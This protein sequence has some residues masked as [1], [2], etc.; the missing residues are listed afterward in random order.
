MKEWKSECGRVELYCGDSAKILPSIKVQVDTVI[1]DPPAGISFMNKKWDKNKG[2]RDKWIEWL[3]GIIGKCPIKPGGLAIVW[4]IPRT[5]H[6]T[7]MAM[8]D[9]G[10]EIRDVITHIFGSGFPKSHNVANSI[11]KKMGCSNRGHA[12]SSGN[13]IHPTTGKARAPGEHLPKYEARTPEGQEWSGYGTGLKPASENWIIGMVPREG[14]FASNA[15]KHGCAGYNIDGCRVGT[16]DEWGGNKDNACKGQIYETLGK[17]RLQYAMPS[18]PKG[19]FPS[20]ILLSH[21]PECE[22]IGKKKVKGRDNNRFKKTDGGSFVAKFNTPPKSDITDKDGN[23]TI[24]SYSCH[25]DCPI[26]MMN[27]QSGKSKS[28]T[29]FCKGCGKPKYGGSSMNKSVTIDKGGWKYGDEGG[30]SRFFENF[31]YDCHPDCPIKMMNEQSGKSKSG[32]GFCKSKKIPYYY[33]DKLHGQDNINSG[34]IGHGDEG[35]ASRFFENFEGK[36]RFCYSPKASKS[37]RNKGCD[38]NTHPTVKPLKLLQWL[39]RLTKT[40]TG[41]TVLDPFMGSG[42]IGVAALKEGREYIGIEQDEEYF[43]IAKARIMYELDEQSSQLF[44]GETNE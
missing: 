17:Y 1:T 35:G 40:P 4:A 15:L 19:R 43:E 10:L 8:E 13:K 30:A 3:A 9:A 14:T 31:E 44:K 2:G 16:T 25:P 37:E 38:K 27:D 28:Q 20:N 41:G 23:E 39:C 18:N 11:D 32:Q 36:C 6:W 21:H 26:K 12:I 7:G 34:Y 5:S 42:S 29:G 33:G 22:K 24:D